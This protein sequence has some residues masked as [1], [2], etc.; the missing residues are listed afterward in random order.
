MIN[1]PE[2]N[3]INADNDVTQLKL[4]VKL[5]SAPR[6]DLYGQGQCHAILI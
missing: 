4:P 2:V 5:S 6:M 3:I 1:S